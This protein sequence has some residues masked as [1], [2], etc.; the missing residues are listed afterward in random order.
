MPDQKEILKEKDALIQLLL[1]EN[2]ELRRQ[3][4]ETHRVL[5]MEQKH[6]IATL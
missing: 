6:L 2:M 5:A 3:L 1:N 4:E